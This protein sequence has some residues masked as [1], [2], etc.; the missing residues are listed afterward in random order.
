VDRLVEGRRDEGLRREVVDLVRLRLLQRAH[1]ARLVEQVALHD[2]DPVLDV[3]DPV[4]VDVARA[5]DEA[6]DLV[7]LRE[8]ELRE[9]AAVLAGDARD[10]GPLG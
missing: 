2:A 1:Q 5:A 3:R 9:V 7:A 8:Q 10:Q 6:V 4:E